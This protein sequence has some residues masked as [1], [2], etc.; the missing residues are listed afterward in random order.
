MR[1]AA[2]LKNSPPGELMKKSTRLIFLV[3]VI[4]TLV[5]CQSVPDRSIQRQNQV[6]DALGMI[7]DMLDANEVV[8]YKGGKYNPTWY[9]NLW[10]D[11][12]HRSVDCIRSA[13]CAEQWLQWD[14]NCGWQAAERGQTLKGFLGLAQK[15]S[16]PAPNCK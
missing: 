16:I 2:Y 13:Q 12:S 10:I 7:P 4:S 9:T 6:C 5:S 15:C 14:S 11:Y 8:D 3:L 1:R